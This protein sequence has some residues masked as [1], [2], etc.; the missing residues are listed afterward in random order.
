MPND[1]RTYSQTEVEHRSAGR[2]GAK[3]LDEEDSERCPWPSRQPLDREG[4]H[5]HH[6]Q[7]Q[8][9]LKDV[10]GGPLV[11]LSSNARHAEG[12]DNHHQDCQRHRDGDPG[13]WASDELAHRLAP[14]WVPWLAPRPQSCANSN[15]HQ[16][17]NGSEDDRQH[18][19]QQIVER[20]DVRNKVST[21]KPD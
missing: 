4:C 10:S 5:R 20:L 15:G 8:P 18:V 7:N 9:K 13:D 1:V 2:Q 12:R 16:G 14:Y 11:G 17:A 6:F 21:K 19:E 3:H